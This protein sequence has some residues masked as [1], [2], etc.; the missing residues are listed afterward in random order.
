[1]EVD[2]IKNFEQDIP[3]TLKQTYQNYDKLAK[4]NKQDLAIEMEKEVERAINKSLK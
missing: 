1:M 4:A 2:V 3:N